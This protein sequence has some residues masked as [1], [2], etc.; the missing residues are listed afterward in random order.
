MVSFKRAVVLGIVLLFS[1]SVFGCGGEPP[2]Q[3][4]PTDTSKPLVAT[5]GRVSPD[6]T[7]PGGDPSVGGSGSPPPGA[8]N[9]AS[10][11]A[12]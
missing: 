4:R 7:V 5:D 12:S 10:G 1:I 8:G 9:E 3:P 11:S 2:S 6:A